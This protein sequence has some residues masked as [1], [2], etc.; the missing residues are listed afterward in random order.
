MNE[1]KFGTVSDD[2]V[3]FPLNSLIGAFHDAKLLKGV[4]AELKQNGFETEDIRSFVGEEGI[5]Q[6][7]FDGTASGTLAELLR[8]FQRIGPGRTFLDR[9]ETFMK[10]GDSLLMV[11]APKEQR[12]QLAA[13]IMRKHSPHP[14]T[15]FGML[16]IEDV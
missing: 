9:Y 14:V 4:I 5:E 11:R 7:D 3:A 6:M 16:V 12:K 10:D 1:N 8:Y 13:D 15:F 2:F